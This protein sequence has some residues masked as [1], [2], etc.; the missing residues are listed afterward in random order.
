MGNGVTARRWYQN[1]EIEGLEVTYEDPKRKDSKFWN[2]GKWRNFI[3]PL[4]PPERETFIEIGCNAGLFLK[5]ATDAGFK[6]V[7]GIEANSQIKTLVLDELPLADVVLLA[8]THYY[9]TIPMLARL[10]DGLRNRALYCIVVSALA[11]RR[12]GNALYDLRSARGYFSD[13][14]E[15]KVIE[16]LDEEGDPAPRVRMYGVLF[17]G[18]LDAL[19]VE[20]TWGLWEKAVS[21]AH[22]HKRAALPAALE[23]FFGKVLAGEDFDVEDTLLYDYWATRA[24]KKGTEWRRG[25]LEYKRRLAEDIRD[26]GMRE[27]V[28]YDR[29]GELLDGGHRLVIAK[30]LGY[31]HVLVR[32]F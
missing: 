2:E 6:R 8:N 16:G 14:R 29:K 11:R 30:E 22:R 1:I 3:E 28:Y 9:L 23:Q 12:S 27:P 10:V 5:L 17:K 32:R 19:D 24:P 21:G 31:K 15:M 20:S 13:W 25:F 7:I 18:N 4:L 26:N